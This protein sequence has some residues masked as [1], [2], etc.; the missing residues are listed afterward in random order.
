[1]NLSC[2]LRRRRSYDFAAS[3]SSCVSLHF[4][5]GFCCVIRKVMRRRQRM[6]VAC[7]CADLFGS[8]DHHHCLK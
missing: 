8:H 4:G 1:M 7:V 6:I 5:F 2:N 3:A